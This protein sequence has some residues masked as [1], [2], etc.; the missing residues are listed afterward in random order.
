MVCAMLANYFVKHSNAGEEYLTVRK[1]AALL[2]V[3][4]GF[5]V[6][7][8]SGAS[9]IVQNH[10]PLS[11]EAALRQLDVAAKD[12]HSLSADVERTKV[13]VVVNDRSTEN[14]TILVRGDRMLLQMK[15]PD[16]RTILRTGDSIYIYNPGLK[17]VEE[18]NLGKN[19]ALFDQ[20]LLLGFGTQGK[21]LQKHYLV[22][23][24][25]EPMLD[26]RK[27]AQ[28]ELT[29]KSE[30]VRNNISKIQIWFDESSWLP[31]QQQFY[32]TGSGDYFIIRYSKIAR[33]P[34]LGDA[35]FKPHWPKGTER[36]KPQG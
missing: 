24:L 27:T 32:E 25:G 18:Y 26:D 31:V 9:A 23:L 8:S 35:R 2:G 6:A 11:M 5:W 4:V 12:F 14:G 22:T 30:Q 36:I 17:R 1:C 3:C 7:V 16:A 20:Y 10:A 15:P 29:P 19:R 13:T 21:D 33:N 28:I 34:D